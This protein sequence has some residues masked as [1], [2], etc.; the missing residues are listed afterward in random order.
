MAGLV[1]KTPSCPNSAARA[2]A[3][4]AFACSL[5][6]AFRPRNCQVAQGLAAALGALNRT[7]VWSIKADHFPGGASLQPAWGLPPPVPPALCHMPPAAT[8]RAEGCPEVS[9]GLPPSVHVVP[10]AP[11]ADL[12]GHPAVRAF[13]THAGIN[14]VHEAAYRSVPILCMPLGADQFD[15]CAKVGAVWLCGWGAWG[16]QPP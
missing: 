11:Q 15:N 3:P 4:A 7:V 5:G 9:L 6:T 2:R 14:S 16:V 10:W 12:L 13:L 1:Y 8:A